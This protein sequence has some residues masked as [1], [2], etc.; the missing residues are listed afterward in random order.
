MSRWLLALAMMVGFAGWGP[1]G[2]GAVALGLTA[3]LLHLSARLSRLV[4]PRCGR[5]SCAPPGE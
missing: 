3:F 4:L 1:R 2:E 5:S